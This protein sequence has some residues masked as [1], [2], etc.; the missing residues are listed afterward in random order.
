MHGLHNAILTPIVA[1]NQTCTLAKQSGPKLHQNPV[2]LP[3]RK[4]AIRTVV[5]F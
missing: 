4:A 1:E 5:A 3:G 2:Y